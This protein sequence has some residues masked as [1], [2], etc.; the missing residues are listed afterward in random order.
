MIVWNFS[1]LYLINV[2]SNGCTFN[3]S[4]YVTNILD[5]LADWCTVLARGSNR[6]LIIHADDLQPHLATMTPRFLEQNAMKRTPHPAYSPDFAPSDFHLFGYVKH[7]IA[8]QEFSDGE[9]LLGA[10]NTIFGGY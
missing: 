5:P 2:L 1:G 8:G 6:K 10:I 4:H 9:A 3:A 7:L